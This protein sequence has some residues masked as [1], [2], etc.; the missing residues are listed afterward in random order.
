MDFG[1]IY[2]PIQPRPDPPAPTLIESCWRVLLA[3]SGLIVTCGLYRDSLHRL[4]VR[5]G[6]SE[7]EL[8]ESRVV[9]DADEGRRMAAAWLDALRKK[10]ACTDAP[11]Q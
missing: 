5:V 3:P 1:R 9:T 10:N 8:L 11:I 7:L 2:T 6:Y 4:E